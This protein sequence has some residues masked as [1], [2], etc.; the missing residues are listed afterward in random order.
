MANR[1]HPLLIK[2][3]TS[4]LRGRLDIKSNGSGPSTRTHSASSS[5]VSSLDSSPPRHLQSRVPSRLKTDSVSRLEKVLF[6]QFANAVKKW[7]KENGKPVPEWLSAIRPTGESPY[8]SHPEYLAD[9]KGRNVRDLHGGKP[10]VRT[11]ADYPA[12]AFHFKSVEA[13]IQKISEEFGNPHATGH[14]TGD[15]AV[16][17][18][19][20]GRQFLLDLWGAERHEYVAFESGAGTT[21]V[22]ETIL[23]NLKRGF[24]HRAALGEEKY[25]KPPVFISSTYD[26]NSVTLGPRPIFP[27]AVFE[28]I[29]T[30]KKSKSPDITQLESLIAKYEKEGRPIVVLTAAASNVSSQGVS[31]SEKIAHVLGRTSEGTPLQDVFWVADLAGD[32]AH[33]RF[34]L[35]KFK[36]TAIAASPHKVSGPGAGVGAFL[37]QDY[38]T[39]FSNHEKSGLLDPAKAGG[40]SPD[41]SVPTDKG[42]VLTY[43][44]EADS[45]RKTQPLKGRSAHVAGAIEELLTP[46]TPNVENVWRAALG[47]WLLYKGLG[48][49]QLHEIEARHKKM[50]FDFVEKFNAKNLGKARFEILG[51]QNQDERHSV[52]SIRFFLTQGSQEQEVPSDRLAKWMDDQAGIQGRPG[53]NC[54]GGFHAEARDLDFEQVQQ[55]QKAVLAGEV[56]KAAYGGYRMDVGVNMTDKDLDYVI[57]VLK[58]AATSRH[59]ELLRDVPVPVDTTPGVYEYVDFS[60]KFTF[61][62]SARQRELEKQLLRVAAEGNSR[63]TVWERLSRP[64]SNKVAPGVT[65]SSRSFDNTAFFPTP[66]KRTAWA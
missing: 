8:I 62:E 41:V 63:Q 3:K 18:L 52:V 15:A 25:Q 54:A 11:Y 40:G 56:S 48:E 37:T 53:C 38:V 47:Y 17:A 66:Q 39:L 42:L 2:P 24:S 21:A 43:V 14:S 4:S 31:T 22:L 5:G 9:L 32:T 61:P 65:V 16:A 10:V 20:A 13:L 12:T 27:D 6:D 59:E 45:S 55:I 30:D 7:A 60:A 57:Q 26:H 46:G 34:P 36:P 49:K 64:K 58:I 1:V 50:F 35:D 23:L 28:V 29:P 33:R 44:G 19:G 51:E